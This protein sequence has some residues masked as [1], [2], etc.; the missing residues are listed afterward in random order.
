MIIWKNRKPISQIREEQKVD[1][2]TKIVQLEQEN[3]DLRFQLQIVQDTV[4]FLLGV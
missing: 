1:P 4:D 3:A 2:N